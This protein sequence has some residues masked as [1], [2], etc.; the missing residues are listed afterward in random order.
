VY[1][2]QIIRDFRVRVP[3]GGLHGAAEDHRFPAGQWID[4]SHDFSSDT[5]YRVTA[6][7]FKRTT[8]DPALYYL[9]P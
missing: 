7:P 1:V 9:S 3:F 4:L 8:A 5:I 2:Y 6:A